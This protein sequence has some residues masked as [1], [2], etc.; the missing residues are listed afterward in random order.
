M[1]LTLHTGLDMST[2]MW[3]SSLPSDSTEAVEGAE[4]GAPLSTPW[5]LPTPWPL[6]APRPLPVVVFFLSAEAQSFGEDEGGG[7]QKRR[8]RGEVKTHVSSLKE[9]A[10]LYPDLT[11]SS[12][13]GQGR[14]ALPTALQ[15]EPCRPDTG[16]RLH[17]STRTKFQTRYQ[18]MPTKDNRCHGTLNENN[19]IQVIVLHC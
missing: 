10:I 7:F 2:G 1:A 18:Q 6:S 3:S 19:G 17:Y 11:P 14:K 9:S 16:T 8:T 13:P 5:S 4:E 15:A 12:T